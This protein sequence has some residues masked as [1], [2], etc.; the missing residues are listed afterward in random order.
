MMTAMETRAAAASLDR[1]GVWALD[2]ARS[3]LGFRIRKFLW[4]PKG[5]FEAFDAA[6]ERAVDGDVRAAVRIDAGSVRTGIGLR[7]AHLRTGHFLDARRH[8]RITFESTS[9]EVAAADRLRIRGD[10]SIRGVKRPYEVEATVE[11]SGEELH[12]RASGA[13]ERAA[14]GVVGPAFFEMGGLML[15]RTVDFVLEAT[16]VPGPGTLGS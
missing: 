8:P 3:T 10:L 7:D 2:P 15:G 16:L 9:V 1:S 13:V 14:F 11:A 4:H 12:L 6:L 5:R